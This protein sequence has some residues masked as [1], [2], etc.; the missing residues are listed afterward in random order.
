MLLLAVS[1]LAYA[2]AYAS[3]DFDAFVANLQSRGGA[4][5]VKPFYLP[6]QTVLPIERN[7]STYRAKPFYLSNRSTFQVRNLYR[8]AAAA[9]VW[10][11]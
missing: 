8:Y 6:S 7:R 9:H 3:D 2:S 1:T 4:V 5:Q 10:R 11:V